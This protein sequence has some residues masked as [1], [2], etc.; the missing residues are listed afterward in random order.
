MKATGHLLALA[1]IFDCVQGGNYFSTIAGT[2]S[3]KEVLQ[4]LRRDKSGDFQYLT[5]LKEKITEAVND[6]N[7]KNVN[8][9]TVIEYLKNSGLKS[10]F[11]SVN[12]F[13]EN[14]KD[15]KDVEAIYVDDYEEIKEIFQNGLTYGTVVDVSEKLLQ[16]LIEKAG[17]RE[18]IDLEA[19]KTEA[20]V[21][22]RNSKSLYDLAKKQLSSE[23][24]KNLVK[25][26]DNEEALSD[27]GE[28]LEEKPEDTKKNELLDFVKEVITRYQSNVSVTLD[29]VL[30]AL[31][32]KST[33][34]ELKK[35]IEDSLVILPPHEER[36][37]SMR[38][39]DMRFFRLA[40]AYK[41]ENKPVMYYDNDELQ[42]LVVTENEVIEAEHNIYDVLDV[43]EKYVKNKDE[44]KKDI[45]TRKTGKKS[46]DGREIREDKDIDDVVS[47]GDIGK[48]R[49]YLKAK[50]EKCGNFIQIV[51]NES[52]ACEKRLN[53]NKL[54]RSGTIESLINQEGNTEKYDTKT[55]APMVKRALKRLNKDIEIMKRLYGEG[56]LYF[57][58][59]EYIRQKS[60]E[61]YEV[62]C[63][64]ISLSG[65]DKINA[66]PLL[67]AVAPDFFGSTRGEESHHFPGS[68]DR[69]KIIFN[70]EETMWKYIVLALQHFN[71]AEEAKEKKENDKN[72]HK[73]CALYDFGVFSHYYLDALIQREKNDKGNHYKLDDRLEDQIK[74]FDFSGVLT[75]S[76]KWDYHGNIRKFSTKL[77]KVEVKL[78]EIVEGDKVGIFRA[79]QQGNVDKPQTEPEKKALQDAFKDLCRIFYAINML[80]QDQESASPAERQ[81]WIKSILKWLN[82]PFK[83]KIVDAQFFPSWSLEYTTPQTLEQ[84]II[85]KV[86]KRGPR[87]SSLVRS[88]ADSVIAIKEIL[89][90]GFDS[91]W[92]FVWEHNWLAAQN[93]DNPDVQSEFL[94]TVDNLRC[95]L[96]TIGRPLGDIQNYYFKRWIC[97]LE[98]SD[99]ACEA[100]LEQLSKTDKLEG[101]PFYKKAVNKCVEP[102]YVVEDIVLRIAMTLSQKVKENPYS[103][104][105]V[106]DVPETGEL[107]SFVFEKMGIKLTEDDLTKIIHEAGKNKGKSAIEELRNSGTVGGVCIGNRWNDL[108][109][110]HIWES[111][112]KSVPAH[113]AESSNVPRCHNNPFEDGLSEEVFSICCA[114]ARGRDVKEIDPDKKFPFIHAFLNSLD[115]SR[116]I[117]LRVGLFLEACRDY[118]AAAR[119]YDELRRLGGI[120]NRMNS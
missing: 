33:T 19:I 32:K 119:Y 90:T 70:Y 26:E 46:K 66:L 23:K 118:E 18:T 56:E 49:E 31:N 69:E 34:D 37:I 55:H 5:F 11:F 22:G 115:D 107:R 103:N 86:G 99:D 113:S 73:L 1:K 27:D 10:L 62:F 17:A 60:K 48:I 64:Q 79:F 2:L 43:A 29:S 14:C 100:A 94:K 21:E 20:G 110:L 9:D 8:T 54:N 53:E 109:D 57:M 7:A 50:Y 97:F 63:E 24:L 28:S 72:Y 42:K 3:Q 74:N 102:K 120:C 47:D 30:G 40:E 25:K 116:Y 85:A 67:G 45:L 93:D 98:S 108:K 71:D 96:K 51:K 44:D 68:S 117:L 76:D 83:K 89:P 101:V 78:K 15:L 82:P 95:H 77:S 87:N 35:S 81:S 111:I 58:S 4:E 59:N 105:T 38:L 12:D 84:R 52:N 75:N 16:A 92:D 13:R 112:L 104:L 114:I 39:N 6:K 80:D 65:E 106:N 41:K 88:L 36:R 61:R 91:V